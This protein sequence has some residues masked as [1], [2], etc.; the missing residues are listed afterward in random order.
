[1]RNSN[2]RPFKR[3]PLRFTLTVTITT[4]MVAASVCILAISYYGNSRS[5]LALS[6]SM[7]SEVSSGIIEKISNL[8]RSAE[9]ANGALNM[10]VGEGILDPRDGPHILPVITS[11]VSHNEGLSSIEVGLPDGSK[12]KALRE[13][14]GSITR[15]S[16][17]RSSTSVTRSYYD[18]K[19]DAPNRKPPIVKSL[20][21]GY[22]ARTRPWFIK[23]LATGRMT[24]T[25]MYVTG[26]TKQFEYSCATP[27]YGADHAL[28]AIVS[29]NIKLA[30]LSEFLGKLKVLQHGSAF[31]LNEHDEVIAVPVRSGEDLDRIFKVSPPGSEDPYRLYPVAEFPDPNVRNA[32]AVSQGHGRRSVEFSGAGGQAYL[33]RLVKFPYGGGADF[34]IGILLPK[35]DVMGP[36]GRNTAYMLLAVLLFLLFAVFIGFRVAR[37][38]SSSLADLAEEVDKVGR[39]ELDSSQTVESHILE[40]ARIDDAVQNM[41]RELR[42]FRKYV[43]VD[44]VRQLNAQKKEAVLEGETRELSIFF[45]DIANF[46]SISEQLTIEDLVQRLGIYFSGMT[47]IVLERGGT[48][49]K[50]IGDSVMAFWGAPQPRENHAQLTCATAL[51]CQQYLDRLA[52]E[53]ES[54]SY[55]LFRTRIGI[56]TGEVIAGNIGSEERINYTIIGD[57]VNLA[58]RLEGLNKFYRTRIIISED[59][60]S[61]AKQDFVARK[62]DRVAVKGRTRGVMIYELV[63]A[64]G[65]LAA[66]QE[67]FLHSYDQAVELYLSRS[68]AEA[69]E[70]FAATRKLSPQGD[71]YP[72]ELLAGRC[73]ELLRNPPGPDWNGV[74]HYETK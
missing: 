5:V 21:E 72:S 7:T 58:S 45:S 2:P 73:E 17:L 37:R 22:D 49:D 67:S 60:Y 61:R 59:T 29:A 26:T 74:H 11:L 51:A 38:I 54:K 9:R 25:D 3:H 40:V 56:H 57:P 30:T 42:S 71:D 70:A 20:K 27:I 15:F 41:R 12:Y 33:A 68:W 55:P 47:R 8:L 34:T 50:Y 18:E 23:A 16:D 6:E 63:A 36:I 13:N 53:W 31:V 35:N 48:L 64:R 52:L 28:R 14:D 10:L 65:E 43:P 24:W 4:L 1:M 69:K 44:V 39:L 32:L 19:P 66:E 46:T 62:L